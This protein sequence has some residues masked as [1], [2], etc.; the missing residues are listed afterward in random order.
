MLLLFTE[1]TVMDFPTLV[2]RLGFPIAIAL[3]GLFFAYKVWGYMTKKLD[4]QSGL[5]KQQ[6]EHAQE[7]SEHLLKT[8]DRISE[9]IE[10]QEDIL[11]AMKGSIEN[12]GR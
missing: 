11:K 5:V 2:D 3:F 7:F 12:I 10:R 4:E 9:S 8:Q 1:T 6:V